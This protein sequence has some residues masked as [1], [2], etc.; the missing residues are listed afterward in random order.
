MIHHPIAARIVALAIV[1]LIFS[2]SVIAQTST[3]RFL[4][5]SAQVPI[6]RIAATDPE[7]GVGKPKFEGLV[8]NI[9]VIPYITGSYNIH[10]G[11][12]FPKSASGLGFGGG[13][14][15]DFTEDG[16]KTGAM[17]DFAYQDMR[18]FAKDGSAAKR[19]VDDT[20]LSTADAEHYFQYLLLEG[21]LKIQGAKKNGYLL[22][23]AS[24]GY[25]TLMETVSRIPADPSNGLPEKSVA[26]LWDGTEY[27]TKLRVDIRAGLGLILANLGTHKLIMEARVGYPILNAISDYKNIASDG[28]IGSWKIITLQ[29]NMGVRI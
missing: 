10:S 29:L 13:L 15:F 11:K 4:F 14:E 1:S 3:S 19:L 16:Q 22:L 28:E 24:V 17:F 5:E 6:A 8:D 7:V 25:A 27:A 26:A 23:G 12:A 2:G 18:A 21:F 9:Y 20:L